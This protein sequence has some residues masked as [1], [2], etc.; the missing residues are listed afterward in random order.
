VTRAFRPN[1]TYEPAKRLILL[2]VANFVVINF[3]E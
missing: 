1:F 3:F 2:E